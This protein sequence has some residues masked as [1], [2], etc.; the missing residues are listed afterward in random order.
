MIDRT[1]FRKYARNAPFGGRL[2]QSQIDGMERIIKEWEKRGLSDLRW[3][4]YML[5]TVFWETQQKMQPVEENLYYTTASRLVAVFLRYIPNETIAKAYLKNPQKL[6]NLVYGNRLGNTEPN[7]GW[8]YRGRG[9]PQLTGKDNYRK[10]GILGAPDKAL[11]PIK[12][13]EILFDGMVNGLYTGRKL[14]HYFNDTT[15][16]PEKARRVVNANDKAKLIAGYY[17]NFL[18]ALNAANVLASI[19]PVPAPNDVNPEAAKADDVPAGQSKSVW[20]T[21][22][23]LFGGAGLSALLGVDNPYAFGIAALLLLMG[24]GALFMFLS[25]RWQVN[26]S[27]VQ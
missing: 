12:S 19:T 17:R 21:I 20:T 5:A 13:V 15:D 6:A 3:L 8:L 7:D 23:G 2:L 14:S 10:F 9:L 18:D 25:G 22:G 4:A 16:E 26:R 1:T 24:G 27:A 11:D